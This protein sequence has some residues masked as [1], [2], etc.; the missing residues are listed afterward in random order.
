VNAGSIDGGFASF[1]ALTTLTPEVAEVLV[2][3]GGALSFN[4]LTELSPE[5][6]AVLAN[7]ETGKQFGSADRRLNGFKKQL[8]LGCAG[9][10]LERPEHLPSSAVDSRGRTQP[11]LVVNPCPRCVA[12]FEGSAGVL[13]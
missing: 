10:G 13:E 8:N 12:N 4:S 6:A 11:I 1:D 5:V 2:K 9:G 3:Y 7:H